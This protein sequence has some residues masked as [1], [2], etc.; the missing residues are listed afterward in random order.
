MKLLLGFGVLVFFVFES[1]G[2][3]LKKK[4]ADSKTTNPV[5][6]KSYK[7]PKIT[8]SWFYQRHPYLKKARK[9][10]A[11]VSRVLGAENATPKVCGVFYKATV[12]AVLLFGSETWKLS[13]LNLKSL[14]EFHIRATRRMAGMQ[15]AR[16]PDRTWTHPSSKEVL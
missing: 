5:V 10:W 2:S 1:A 4:E 12:Q 9:S 3:S 6:A 16:N 8:S 7:K 14:E 11:Q 15:P 13:P